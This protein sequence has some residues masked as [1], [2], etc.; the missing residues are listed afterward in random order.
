LETTA[1]DELYVRVKGG[2]EICVPAGPSITTYVLIEQED[3]FEKEIA[4]VRRLLRPGMRAIDIGANYGTYTLAMAQAVAPE[5]RV[6]A[7]EPTS[8]TA[9]YL[10][11]T[12]AR[13][14]LP[15][16]K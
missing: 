1:M 6:W 14:I 13:T 8:A 12:I 4:F 9:R 15:T 3:W 10:G 5:G 16:W 11:K 2:G 7:Y